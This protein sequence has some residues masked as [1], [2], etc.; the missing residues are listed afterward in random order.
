MTRDRLSQESCLNPIGSTTRASGEATRERIGSCVRSTMSLIALSGLNN[1]MAKKLLL[2][3]GAGFI[4]H[5]F[6]EAVL[7]QTDWHIVCL[8]RLDTSGNL[9]RL[10]DIDVWEKEKRRVK[11]YHHDLRAEINDS[12]A[13][14]LILGDSSSE[15]FDAG[16]VVPFDYI[17]HMAAGTHVDR[18]I[19][20][21]LGFVQDNVVGTANLLNAIRLFP[22]LKEDGRFLYFSTDEVFGPAPEGVLYKEWDRHNPN[23]PYAAAKSGGEDMAVAFANT[24]KIPTVVTHTMNVFGERQH[25]E[26][27]I[28]MCIKKIL[29]GETV[30]VHANKDKTKAGTRFYIHARNLSSAVLYVLEHGKVLDGSATQGKYNIVGDQEVS[31]LDMAQL[32]SSFLGKELKYEMTDFHSSRPGHDLRYGLDGTLLKEAGWQSPLDFENSLRNT[33]MW[34]IDPKH[35]YWIGL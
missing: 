11:F 31:N 19:S 23:N 35:K 21:P 6:I 32:I 9:N 16:K 30:T 20:D 22:L 7:K 15:N 10:T 12:V 33:V 17:V 5:H 1:K 26:K 24:Y 3:G 4:G 29:N 13:R 25:P 28:P 14:L 18:S 34:S 8:D 2:T 27:F